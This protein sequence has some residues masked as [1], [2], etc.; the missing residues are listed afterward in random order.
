M[1][2]SDSPHRKPAARKTSS[3]VGG[4]VPSNSPLGNIVRQEANKQGKSPDAAAF[5]AAMNYREKA[6]NEFQ[7]VSANCSTSPMYLDFTSVAAREND[8]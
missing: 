8:L 7:C 1:S 2:F 3:S 5:I 4:A 6:G